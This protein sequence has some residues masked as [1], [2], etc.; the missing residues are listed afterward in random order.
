MQK[1]GSPNPNPCNFYLWGTLKHEF[2]EN[3]FRTEDE[4]KMDAW[5][6]LPVSLAKLTC[7]EQ[8]SI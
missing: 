8:S 4:L 2:D 1:T 7:Y 6:V 5:V 3:N